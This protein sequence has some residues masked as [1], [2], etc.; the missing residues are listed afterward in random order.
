[1][2]SPHIASRVRRVRPS[3]TKAATARAAELRR[4]GRDIIVLSQG[5]PDFDTPAH[6]RQAAARAMEQGRTRYTPVAGVE[7]LREAVARTL[8]RDHG[9]RYHADQVSVGCGAKQV[10]FNALFA[11]LEPG[12]EV[13]VPVPAW[14]SYP[15]MVELAGG[16]TVAVPCGAAAGFK[17]TAGQLESALTGRTRWVILNSPANPTG[18][19]Y[20]QAEL[21][22]LAEVLERHPAVCVLCDDIYEKIVYPPAAFAT[23]LSVAPALADRTLV[24]NGVSKAYGMTGWRVGYG[25]GPLSLVRAMNTIQGQSSSHTSSISQYAAIAALDGDQDFLDVTRRVY[26]ERRDLVVD[27]LGA[28]PGLSCDRP[29]GAFYV[30]PECRK[31]FGLLTPRGTML[32]TDDD[33]VDYLLDAA[34]VAVVAGSAFLFPGHFR[35]SYASGTAVLAEACD[36]IRRALAALTLRPAA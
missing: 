2:S 17:L 36:R 1:M 22:A 33:V 8:E 15:D 24:V 32:A 3:A 9:L 23:L 31:L 12:D 18:A 16:R 21:R 26:R 29:D 4:T 19:V 35:L 34:G 13:I 11:T 28:I 20:T 6:I 30:F 5:E 7:P 27:A 14:V 10:I 25:A